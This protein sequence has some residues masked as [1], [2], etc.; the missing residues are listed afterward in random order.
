MLAL[1][2]E[3]L[4][5]PNPVEVAVAL[6]IS[7]AVGESIDDLGHLRDVLMRRNPVLLLKIPV[8]GFERQCGVMLED[9]LIA[10]FYAELTDIRGRPS[11]LGAFW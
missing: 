5:S 3:F 9:A 7:R 6:L 11:A 10:P 8:A 2:R 1:L 4:T